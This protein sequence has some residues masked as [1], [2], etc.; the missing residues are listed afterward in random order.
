MTSN[1][2]A[3]DPNS[4]FKYTASPNPSWTYGQG[5]EATPA[6][7]AWAEGEKKGWKVVDTSKED[8]RY[9]LLIPS[10]NDRLK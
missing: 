5:I 2:P 10:D 9:V 4:D 3:Y 6:G 7:R 8:P 1:L